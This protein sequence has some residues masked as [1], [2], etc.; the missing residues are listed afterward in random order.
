[1]KTTADPL[2]ELAAITLEFQALATPPKAALK[3]LAVLQSS[4]DEDA[5]ALP[6]NELPPIPEGLRQRLEE[7]FAPVPAPEAE[8][9]TSTSYA[10][11][12]TKTKR[13]GHDF[14]SVIREWWT[15]LNSQQMGLAF[16]A[17]LLLGLV[18]TFFTEDAKPTLRGSG[19]VVAGTQAHI[20]LV[21]TA[22]NLE[23]FM[24]TWDGEPPVLAA[25]ADLAPKADKGLTIIADTTAGTVTVVR[26]GTAE[27]AKPVEQVIPGQAMANLALAVQA[28][29]Q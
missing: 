11:P 20:V 6:P 17:L 10:P 27:P 25:S 2:N 9:E 4:A 26:D 15:R 23:A 7:K 29:L 12:T 21:G 14:I 16:A 28:A 5:P 19:Q 18:S 1:M 8:P 24:S 13:D 3:A 22:A